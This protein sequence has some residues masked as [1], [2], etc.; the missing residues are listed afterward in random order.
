M[1]V[2]LNKGVR[3]L[4]RLKKM[5]LNELFKNRKGQ[6]SILFGLI[7]I[8]M[9]AVAGF[10]IDFQQTIKRKHKVQLVMDSAVLAAARVKQTGAPDADVK[11]AVQ[12]YLDGQLANLVDLTCEAAVVTVAEGSEEIDASIRCEQTT[13]IMKVIGQN[14]SLIHI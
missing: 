3:A 1:Y 13:A 7:L 6:V 5:R 11:L 2:D 10:A 4:R 9:V 8:P 12:Q 14:L